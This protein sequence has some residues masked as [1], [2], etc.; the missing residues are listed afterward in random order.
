MLGGVE[1]WAIKSQQENKTN[2]LL[3]RMLHGMSVHTLGKIGLGMNASER[4]LG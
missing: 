3:V 2:V 4:K 1:C